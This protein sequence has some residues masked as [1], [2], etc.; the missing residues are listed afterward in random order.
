MLCI[1]FKIPIFTFTNIPSKLDKLNGEYVSYGN[2]AVLQPTEAVE[3][4]D[5]MKRSSARKIMNLD[6]FSLKWNL[7]L[8][9][10]LIFFKRGK[11]ESLVGKVVL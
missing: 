3:P 10:G 11:E 2:W 8:T 5:L 9:E 6:A 7:H 1:F 4:A